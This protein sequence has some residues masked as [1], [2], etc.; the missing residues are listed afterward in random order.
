[1][2]KGS[3]SVLSIST[4]PWFHMTM[5]DYFEETMVDTA[6]RE[7]FH[8][9]K[10]D[11]TA[12]VTKSADGIFISKENLYTN[13][14]FPE[15]QKL[16]RS[17][18]THSFI[19]CFPN[20]RKYSKLRLYGEAILCMKNSEHP[21]HDEA[22]NKVLSA[23]TYLYPFANEGT[24]IYDENKNFVKQ[25]EWKTNRTMVFAGQTGVTWHSYKS[26]GIR[27]TLNSFLLND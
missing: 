4:K 15:T 12:F 16:L 22:E 6:I 8:V 21:I 2:K 18:D 1:M 5:D 23:V 7:I 11:Q 20:I 14:K 3:K 13:P 9:L 17:R 24:L 25:V 10:T 19:P 27:L 26:S